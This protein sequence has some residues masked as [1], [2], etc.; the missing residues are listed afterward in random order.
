MFYGKIEGINFIQ[1]YRGETKYEETRYQPIRLSTMTKEQ[2]FYAYK[3]LAQTNDSHLLLESGRGGTLCMAGIDP[4]VT[5]Q[6]LEGDKLQLTWRD[7]TEEVR[8]GDPL[9]LL[10]DFVQSYEIGFYSRACLNFKV[11]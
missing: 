8:E 5:L 1:G 9:E 3:E 4:L 2:F 11:V 6:T 10:T 7:G